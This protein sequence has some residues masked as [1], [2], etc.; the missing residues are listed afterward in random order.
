M[1]VTM[2]IND[3]ERPDCPQCSRPMGRMSKAQSGKKRYRCAK[4][5]TSTTATRSTQTREPGNTSLEVAGG[6]AADNLARLKASIR[7]GTRRFI[8]TSAANNTRVHPGFMAALET[9]ARHKDAE[10]VVIPIHYKNISLY[11]GGQQFRKWW[12]SALDDY[13]IDAEL[14]VGGVVIDGD[15]KIQATVVNPLEGLHDLGGPRWRIFGHPQLGMLPIAMPG[16]RIP[17]RIYTTGACTQKSYS[18]TKAGKKA[19]F[20]HSYAALLIEVEGRTAFVRQLNYDPMFGG[21]FFDL[22]EFFSSKG[23]VTSGHRATVL[24]TGDEHIKFFDKRVRRAT[25]DAED[26]ISKTL[27]PEWIV[28][29]DIFDAYAVSHHHERSPLKQYEKYAGG[30][31]DARG[32]LDEVVDFIDATTPEGSTNAIVA[33]NHHDHLDKWLDRADAKTD[34]ANAHLILELQ[35]A[36]RKAIDEGREPYALPL[37]LEPRLSAPTI[38]LDRNTPFIPGKG[39]DYSQHGDVGVN[40]SRGSAAALS[41]SA[42]KMTIGHSH[43]ARIV[44][45]V[46]QVGKSPGR[47]EY[48]NGLSDHT[49]THLIEYANGKRTLVDI[50]K[51]KWRGSD[52]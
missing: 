52:K 19:E 42:L 3:P 37:Y 14:P 36:Q 11:T 32:E 17:K 46:Y 49:N 43:G 27:S 30:H 48:E 9:A 2:K 13:L 6:R 51:G 5:Q 35:A 21:G 16:D 15:T 25:Y 44:K 38:F 39:A 41:K 34:H 20:H 28:R 7:G 26:S 18:R 50:F 31:N 24:A 33:A 4:C 22:D 10:L 29:Q 1:A 45:G 23:I 8:V 12:D 40:G 47:L